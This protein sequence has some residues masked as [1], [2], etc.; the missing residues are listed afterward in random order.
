[1]HR[2]AVVVF[3]LICVVDKRQASILCISSKA[4]TEDL[5][6]RT[7]ITLNTCPYY[8]FNIVSAR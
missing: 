3:V 6:V 5:I 7:V 2:K 8:E 1:M 4:Q